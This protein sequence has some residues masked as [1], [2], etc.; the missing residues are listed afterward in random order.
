MNELENM[1]YKELVTLAKAQGI[2]TGGISKEGLIEALKQKAMAD[3]TEASADINPV[4]ND[5]TAP[6]PLVTLDI[7]AGVGR[8][9]NS[10]EIRVQKIV[11]DINEMFKKRNPNAKAAYN[12]DHECI[13]FRGG[14]KQAEDVTIH[15]PEKTIM[16]FAEFYVARV[17]TNQGIVGV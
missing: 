5:T 12:A 13:Q 15:Q 10:Q 14:A 4:S 1:E 8:S 6:E 2:K 16:K 3:I 11:D 17:I 9:V 7:S